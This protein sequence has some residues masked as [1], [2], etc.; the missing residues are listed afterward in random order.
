MRPW[1][2]VIGQEGQQAAEGP[3][4][5]ATDCVRWAW[6]RRGLGSQAESMAVGAEADQQED[7]SKVLVLDPPQVR[8]QRHEVRW[9]VYVA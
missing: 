7:R 5:P 6:H 3:G 2:C 9:E 8:R 4:Q 1:T